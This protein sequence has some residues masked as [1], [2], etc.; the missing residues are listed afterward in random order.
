[1]LNLSAT[2]YVSGKPKIE[3]G[4]Y[5]DSCTISLRCK[6]KGGKHVFYVNAKFYGKQMAVIEKYIEDGDQVSVNGSV[7]LAV[8]KTKKD[9]TKYSAIYMSGNDFCLPS[10][11]QSDVMSGAKSKPQQPSEEE[12][13]F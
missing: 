13:P 7:A 4:D 8:E 1:M 2:G 12:V 9:G 10:R 11:G 5:G 6:G 3:S